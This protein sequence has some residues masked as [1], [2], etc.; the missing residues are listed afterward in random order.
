MFRFDDVI[1]C[2]APLFEILLHC[3]TS[4]SRKEVSKTFSS[5]Q[6]CCLVVELATWCFIESQKTIYTASYLCLC[7]LFVT[8]HIRRFFLVIFSL[9]KFTC[10]L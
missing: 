7:L 6:N 5:K 4:G 8:C 9:F 2:C 10:D 1:P 3:A